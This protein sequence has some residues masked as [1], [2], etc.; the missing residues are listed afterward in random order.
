MTPMLGDA[1]FTLNYQI[2]KL[3]ETGKQTKYPSQISCKLNSGWK[4]REVHCEENYIEVSVRRNIFRL[5]QSPLSEE[6]DTVLS[7]EMKLSECQVLIRRSNGTISLSVEEARSQGY[8]VAATPHRIVFRSPYNKP[9]AEI[10]MV[11]DIEVE[12]IGATVVFRQNWALVMIE[13]TPACAMNAGT[14][15]GSRVGWTVPRVMQPLTRSPSQFEDKAVLMGVDGQVVDTATMKALDYRLDI[16]GPHVTL[17]VPFGAG[18]GL[19]ESH[20]IENQYNSRYTV[21]FY[22]QHLWTDDMFEETEH[23]SFKLVG[24]P[25]I[26]S[27]PF[28]VDQTNHEERT[29]TVYLGI[30]PFDVALVALTL[31]GEPFTVAGA[32]QSGYPITE[33][34]H[35][36]GTHA[37]ILRVP[38]KDPIVPKMYLGDGILQYSLDINF[39]LNIMPQEEPYYHPVSVVAELKDSF[40]ADFSGVCT[41]T[42]ITF[43]M[44]HQNWGYLWEVGIGHH[45][46][47]PELAAKHGYIMQNDGQSL[48]LEVPLF[49]IGYVYEDINLR[50]FFG[51]FEV[52]SRD[53]KTLKIAKRVVKRC[54]FQTNELIVCGPGGLVT[55]VISMTAT[56]PRVDPRRTTLLDETCKPREND[57][58]RALFAF[59]V[60]SCGTR[61]MVDTNYVTYENE[62]V[63]NRELIPA[64]RTVITRDSEFRLTVLCY[65]PTPDT[66]RLLTDRKFLQ[67][68]EAP[69]VGSI[70][71]TGSPS[72]RKHTQWELSN[73]HSGI[74]RGKSFEELLSDSIGTGSENS[75]HITDFSLGKVTNSQIG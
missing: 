8:V 50:Q 46:L 24:T 17:S 12:T 10:Q 69:G 35:A 62:V 49:T 30:F 16:D 32:I 14:F 3:D 72:G 55:V 1:E 37:Y 23:R 22:L 4:P 67:E 42:G 21:L 70:I 28:T 48:T 47:T 58:T 25:Y 29:F 60:N 65:Y 64:N 2:V 52:V 56:L 19:Y 20:V 39:T 43:K 44:A 61:V 33:V 75:P 31:N 59:Q 27:M 15:N 68:P 63:F 71:A 40:P 54:L 9:W 5:S 13:T 34:P 7:G 11:D 51:S 26:P 74:L 6:W 66:I 57:D 38:F 73:M 53:T 41:E 36:N 45:P 18:G